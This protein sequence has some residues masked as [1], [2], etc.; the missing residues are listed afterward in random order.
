MLSPLFLGLTSKATDWRNQHTQ[1]VYS[2][3]LCDFIETFIC[4]YLKGS[5]RESISFYDVIKLINNWRV[6]LPVYSTSTLTELADEQVVEKALHHLLGNHFLPDN[7]K[8]RKSLFF[9]YDDEEKIITLAENQ[10][11]RF[12]LLPADDKTVEASPLSSNEINNIPKEMREKLKCKTVNGNKEAYLSESF[13]SSAISWWN[14]LLLN[15]KEL[16][17]EII[18]KFGCLARFIVLL[19]DSSERENYQTALLKW[20]FIKIN[21]QIFVDRSMEIDIFSVNYL[22]TRNI[23]FL[24]DY[25]FLHLGLLRKK[26][27]TLDNQANFYLIPAEANFSS[28]TV[29]VKPNPK[30]PLRGWSSDSAIRTK[31]SMKKTKSDALH[32][33][34]GG[35]SINKRNCK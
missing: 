13:F 8:K 14:S 24:F 19:Q 23:P 7:I 31:K 28:I 30:K 17:R 34:L 33:M 25:D 35:F 20:I 11:F 29:L 1:N 4:K 27:L 2:D 15:R 26:S 12:Q 10:P 3:F 18:D 6:S 5:D 32:T 21:R 22:L 16:A 9:D